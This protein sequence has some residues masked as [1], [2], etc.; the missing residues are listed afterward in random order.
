M[1]EW[2]FES[3]VEAEFVAQNTGEGEECEF[4]SNNRWS[5]ETH[6]VWPQ[7]KGNDDDDD[8]ECESLDNRLF[9]LFQVL[10]MLRGIEKEFTWLFGDTKI[11]ELGD[12]L[13]V[14]VIYK[15]D[16]RDGAIISG[17]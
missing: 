17:L 3:T 12:V 13:L 16:K 6:D 5:I 10:L 15:G 8:G 11:V 14:L 7:L 1:L 4:N 9:W 2:T